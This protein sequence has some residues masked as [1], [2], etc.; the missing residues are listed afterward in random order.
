M[1][2]KQLSAEMKARGLSIAT[3]MK[4][5][6]MLKVLESGVIW[7]EQ[8]IESHLEPDQADKVV[9]AMEEALDGLIGYIRGHSKEIQQ[10]IKS[11]V[12]AQ[13]RDS[14]GKGEWGKIE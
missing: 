6:D 8:L 2:T 12:K 10:N 1:T 14:N 9:D 7:E 5:E 4:K 3:K 13:R 11:N